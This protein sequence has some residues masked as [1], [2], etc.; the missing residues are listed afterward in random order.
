MSAPLTARVTSVIQRDFPAH[1]TD[2][3]AAILL[4]GCGDDL[5]MIQGPLEIERIRLAVL[6]LAEGD[7]S[8][9]PDHIGMARVDWRDVLVAAEFGTDLTAHLRWADE[10]GKP[11]NAP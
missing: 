11:Q 1:S 8:V 6:K 2:L 4:D 3:I 9:L 10:A 5:P 7:V